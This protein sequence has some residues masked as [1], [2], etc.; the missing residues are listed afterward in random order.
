MTKLTRILIVVSA[1]IA[2]AY[3][4]TYYGNEIAIFDGTWNEEFWT[5]AGWLVLC[6]IPIAVVDLVFTKDKS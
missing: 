3:I 4:L 1:L 5:V 6:I 2:Y